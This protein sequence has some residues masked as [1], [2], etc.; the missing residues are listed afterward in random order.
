MEDRDSSEH[1]SSSLTDLMTSLMVIFILLLLVFISHTASKDAAL[2]DTLLAELKK[3]LIPQ[4][5]DRTPQGFKDSSIISDPKNPDAILVIVPN[6]LMGFDTQKSTLKKDGQQFLQTHIPALADVLCSLKFQS[7]IDSIIVEGH[8][9]TQKFGKTDEESQNNNLK[10]SQD[11][12]MAVVEEALADLS[13]KATRACFLEKLSATGRGEQ[14]AV[15]PD[16]PGPDASEK[17]DEQSRRVIFK[18]HVRASDKDN[19]AAKVTQ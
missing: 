11:R 4:G 17:A 5:K 6:N 12:S 14:E 19:I 3:D 10:L 16:G 13:G 15:Q 8:T 7:G 9:D 1:L 2:R 18:I